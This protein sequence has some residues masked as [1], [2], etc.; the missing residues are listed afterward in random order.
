[1]CIYINNYP[2]MRQYYSVSSVIVTACIHNIYWKCWTSSDKDMIIH[3]LPHIVIAADKTVALGHATLLSAPNKKN[4][5]LSLAC[6]CPPVFSLPTLLDADLSF[7][8]RVIKALQS[9]QGVENGL[10]SLYYCLLMLNSFLPWWRGVGA[11]K[12]HVKGW[13]LS[14]KRVVVH[15][16]R[17]TIIYKFTRINTHW[18]EFLSLFSWL[19]Q[20]FL[21]QRAETRPKNICS[22]VLMQLY[23]HYYLK[24]T[25]HV[26]YCIAAWKKCVTPPHTPPPWSPD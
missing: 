26:R 8:G 17:H 6:T 7:R 25:Q 2:W 20:Q 11:Y 5:P 1:M 9:K 19:Q 23:F 24:T 22:E 10:L 18:S 13:W 3:I 21:C 12:H 16:G 4:L 14:C 15:K